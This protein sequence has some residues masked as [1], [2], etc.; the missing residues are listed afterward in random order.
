MRPKAEASSLQCCRMLARLEAD[1]KISAI[2]LIAAYVSCMRC[3][4]ECLPCRHAHGY[5]RLYIHVTGSVP[6]CVRCL[7]DIPPRC[8]AYGSCVTIR[9]RPACACAWAAWLSRLYTRLGRGSS[10]ATGLHGFSWM[11]YSSLPFP[12]TQLPSAAGA[13]SEWPPRFTPE[14][15]SFQQWV[16]DPGVCT[17]S[18]LGDPSAYTVFHSPAETICLSVCGL[19]SAP[20]SYPHALVPRTISGTYFLV[21]LFLTSVVF[22]FFLRNK[23]LNIPDMMQA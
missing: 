9:C 19:G 13:E 2:N 5:T 20:S 14:A 8:S 17:L 12:Q 4:C 16:S 3:L 18:N 23:E 7:F 1:V 21:S 6:R 22:V 15:A 11:S 10:K